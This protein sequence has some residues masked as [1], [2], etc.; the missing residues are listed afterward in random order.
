[1]RRL[2]AT[3]LTA[4]SLAASGGCGSAREATE[5]DCNADIA[6]RDVTYRTHQQLD[7]DAPR[8]AAPLGEGSV[9]DCGGEGIDEVSVHAVT[10]VDPALAI[11]VVDPDWR[12]VFVAEDVSPREW[13]DALRADPS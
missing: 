4:L 5:G 13:P 9:L 7:Q 11:V 6:Y 10:G 8:D 3:L 1:V 12:G 2:G